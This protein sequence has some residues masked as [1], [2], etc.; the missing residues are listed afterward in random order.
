MNIHC[1]EIY[2]NITF[3]KLIYQRA[4]WSRGWG[5]YNPPNRGQKKWWGCFL[6]SF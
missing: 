3:T 5:L 1:I 4:I 6:L 2:T